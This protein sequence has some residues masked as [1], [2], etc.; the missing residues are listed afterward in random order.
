[1]QVLGTFYLAKDYVSDTRHSFSERF[2]SHKLTAG[3]STAHAIA[4]RAKLNGF[5]IQ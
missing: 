2:Y 1:M 4:A 3:D 5:T